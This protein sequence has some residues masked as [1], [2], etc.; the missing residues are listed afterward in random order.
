M[1]GQIN[2]NQIF[3]FIVGIFFLM[4]LSSCGY[5]A[6]EETTEAIVSKAGTVQLYHATDTSVEADEGRYQLMQP[7]NPPAALEEVIEQLKLD[8]G[9]TI[10]RYAIDGNK[11]ITLYIIVSDDVS[12]ES[13]LLNQA[14]IYRSVKGLDSGEISM[15]LVDGDG[16]I[17]E[18]AT[19][20]DA[21]FEYWE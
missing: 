8:E 17:L 21:S 1:N 19:F 14:A 2:K 9:M 16:N 5:V 3:A 18:E 13:K 10:D 4:L 7:D 20:T 11:N 12:I 6:D 15:Q